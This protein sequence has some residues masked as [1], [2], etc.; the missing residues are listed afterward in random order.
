LGIDF[1][2]KNGISMQAIHQL[3]VE[4]MVDEL[5]LPDILII[6]KDFQNNPVYDTQDVFKY[7]KAYISKQI[8]TVKKLKGFLWKEKSKQVLLV[9]SEEEPWHVA[10]SEDLKDFQPKLDENKK[11][12]IANLNSLIGFMTNFKTEDYVVFKTKN[13]N[14]S[15]DAGARCD[16]NSN[17]S[18]SIDILDSIVGTYREPP[19]K[20]IYNN[21]ICILQELYLRLYDKER[22]NKKRWFLSPPEAVISNIEKYSTV[23]KKKKKNIKK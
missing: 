21:V 5:Y 13:I 11:N 19:S 9:S 20:K 15:R 16:Q 1:L 4:H 12:I 6:L 22:K 23:E 2:M 17:K 18:K 8:L 3:I 10:E 14:N 7:I